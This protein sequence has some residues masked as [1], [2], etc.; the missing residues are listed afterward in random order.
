MIIGFTV[1]LFWI[2]SP[3][4]VNWQL[5]RD[6]ENPND[7]V[8]FISADLRSNTARTFVAQ[9]DR[10]WSQRNPEAQLVLFVSKGKIGNYQNI[11]ISSDDYDIPANTFTL[12]PISGPAVRHD[13]IFNDI[14][15]LVMFLDHRYQ[16]GER[17]EISNF[18]STGQKISDTAFGELTSLLCE[19][20]NTTF[21]L[22]EDICSACASGKMLEA[23]K[24]G[25]LGEFGC[26]KIITFSDY[27]NEQITH[28]ID[29]EAFPFDIVVAPGGMTEISVELDQFYHRNPFNGL[30]LSCATDG[31]LQ[32]IMDTSQLARTKKSL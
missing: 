5:R 15:S 26:L 28:Y 6:L 2:D 3:H 1:F 18:L 32:E 31:V 20:Q 27:S 10:Y 12:F 29:R 22:W 16:T 24:S 25:L 9:M 19:D 4:D 13:S 11:K 7:D 14:D 17:F 23:L 30:V 21:I 8:L